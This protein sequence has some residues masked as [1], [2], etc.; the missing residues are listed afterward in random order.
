MKSLKILTIAILINSVQCYW[1]NNGLFFGRSHPTSHALCSRAQEVVNIFN[2]MLGGHRHL[3]Q[4]CEQNLNNLSQNL[5][6]MLYQVENSRLTL[7]NW[8]LSNVIGGILNNI[9]QATTPKSKTPAHVPTTPHS[10][11]IPKKTNTTAIL[12]ARPEPD[13]NGSS[14]GKAKPGSHGAPGPTGNRGSHNN[15]SNETAKQ[16]EHHKKPHLLSASGPTG[17]RSSHNNSHNKPASNG[18]AK[19]VEHHKKPQPHN[20]SAPTGNRG[21]HNNSHNKPASNGTAKPVE[22]HKKPQPHNASGPTGNRGSHN[23]SHH[24]PASNETAK[25]VTH[26]KKP[27]SHGSP[28]PVGKPGINPIKPVLHGAPKPGNKFHKTGSH[29]APVQVG[30]HGFK[31]AVKPREN[32]HKPGPNRAN[33]P[34]G[35]QNKPTSHG[36]QRPPGN[37]SS[38]GAIGP[39]VIHQQSGKPSVKRPAGTNGSQVTPGGT[40]GVI[41]PAEGHNKSSIAKVATNSS[42]N[43][44][45]KGS[46]HSNNNSNVTSAQNLTSSHGK[47]NI[48]AVKNSSAHTSNPNIKSNLTEHVKQ[49]KKKVPSNH[50]GTKPHSS[51]SNHTSSNVSQPPINTTTIHLNSTNTLQQSNSSHSNPVGNISAT[52]LNVSKDG[53][54][55]QRSQA[56]CHALLTR[57][58]NDHPLL[59]E[60]K[61]WYHEPNAYAPLRHRALSKVPAN[62]EFIE[63]MYDI[64]EMLN[65]HN[66][67][68]AEFNIGQFKSK[69]GI[70]PKASPP[71]L[72]LK[73]NNN[74]AKHAQTHADSCSS[75]HS[76]ESRLSNIFGFNFIGESLYQAFDTRWCGTC[77]RFPSWTIAVQAWFDEHKIY[78]NQTEICKEMKNFSRITYNGNDEVGHFTQIISAR[79]TQI[80]CGISVCG[81][82]NLHITCNYAEIGNF[83]DSA[84]YRFDKDKP[85][86]E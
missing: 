67:F 82:C 76:A 52:S 69:N 14:R 78:P 22:H 62:A 37:H 12:K 47:T 59:P 30:N 46:P 21:S 33:N 74:L 61:A 86:C 66:K 77:D 81:S 3:R 75:F 71:I 41:K 35:S 26:H 70:F 29:F 5:Q 55:V 13:N 60:S 56:R 73:W 83:V 68:R 49:F 51:A 53:I 19:P 42:K 6:N 39:T 31:G 57:S 50:N 65:I 32:H 24:K 64:V 84:V 18:T 20:A 27:G 10:K 4:N 44:T 54:V 25:P 34:P 15:S 58:I 36:K 79:T 38:H 63:I 2:R 9:H 45:V 7:Q 23:N 17:N 85:P 43:L 1:L 28:R 16:V 8:F 80:G 40:H 72:N 48:S 11:G